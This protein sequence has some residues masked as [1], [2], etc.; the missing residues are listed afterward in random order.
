MTLARSQTVEAEGLLPGAA[1]APVADGDA[2]PG[3]AGLPEGGTRTA[4]RDAAIV[5]GGVYVA[6]GF[7]FIAGILQKG[8]L[9]PSNTGYWA[10]MGTVSTLLS[11]APL[12]T[13]NG[14]VRQIPYHRGRGDLKAAA[15]VADTG[16]SFGILASGIAGLL[17][18]AVAVL[19]GEGW[20]PQIRYGMILLGV[21]APLNVLSDAHE[22][23]TQSTRRFDASAIVV[24]I[25]GLVILTI[26]TAFVVWLG[27]YGMFAGLALVMTVSLIAYN[28]L[29]VTSLRRPAFR[30]RIDRA[31]VP[32]LMRFGIPMLLHSQLWLLFLAVDNLIVAGFLDVK[33]LGYYAL[34]FSVTTYIQLLPRSIGAALGVRMIERF[35]ATEDVG[36]IRGYVSEVQRI[37]AMVLIPILVAGAFFFMPVLVRQA[38]PAFTPAIP[39]VHI[40][41]AASF[42]LSLSTL[43][44]KLLLAAG[45]RWRLTR[46]TLVCLL[47]NAAANFI[48][49]GVLDGGIRGAALATAISYFT[50]FLIMSG[51]ALSRSMDL[52]A[53][54]AHIAALVA[55]F[56]W[57]TGALWG[58][59][60]LIG[61]G[62]G[63]PVNDA[64]IAAGKLTLFVVA[65]VPWFALAERRGGALTAI[66]DL[67]RGAV[68][69]A[70]R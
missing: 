14:A 27:Y 42:F 54:V 19:F 21:L 36:S 30:W 6:Q 18:V 68:R 4:V 49:V 13:F 57:V 43:P 24:I 48:A 44:I 9:G 47:I 62:G 1:E 64:L 32:E 65:M 16:S 20:A 8:L 37:L 56:A 55:V 52:R 61:P 41:V 33:N 50:L 66:R 45:Y 63:G 31:R 15:A 29:G 59:E 2:Y 11:I 28:R 23:I 51:Y 69:R 34:A 46:L 5:T 12:G 39:V 25:K 7:L 40:M 53:V 70:R 26:Q 3:L 38:L 67:A 22:S 60:E 17:M 10:L 35:G 58:I